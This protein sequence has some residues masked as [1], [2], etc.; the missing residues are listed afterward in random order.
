MRQR[1][2]EISITDYK[3]LSMK[4]TMSEKVHVLFYI[5]A[6]LDGTKCK[7]FRIFTGIK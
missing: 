4:V 7:Q 2:E 1:C 3:N 6:R 5:T